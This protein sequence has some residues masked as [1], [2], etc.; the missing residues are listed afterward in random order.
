MK[1]LMINGKKCV[2]LKTIAQ[3]SGRSMST[4]YA[5]VKTLGLKMPEAATVEESDANSVLHQLDKMSSRS[6]KKAPE[7][8]VNNLSNIPTEELVAEIKRRKR[9]LDALSSLLK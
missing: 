7:K 3:Q 2:A 4:V 9:E 6:R 1:T 8:R 5:A